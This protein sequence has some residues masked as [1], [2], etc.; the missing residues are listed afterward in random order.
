MIP[1]INQSS[2]KTAWKKGWKYFHAAHIA[3]TIPPKSEAYFAVGSAIHLFLLENEKFKERVIEIPKEVL[4]KGDKKNTTAWD[5]FAES[6]NDKVLLKPAEMQ[7]VLACVESIMQHPSAMEI[8]AAP[9]HVEQPI[10]A[11]IFGIKARGIPDICLQRGGVVVDVKSTSTVDEYEFRNQVR[12]LGYHIQAA[13]YLE[14]CSAF[15][16]KRYNQFVF[17]AVE[18]EPPYRCRCYYLDEAFLADGRMI[19]EGLAQEYARRYAAN[20]WLEDCD[21]SIIL[22]EKGKW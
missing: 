6:N 19:A 9:A 18:T 12:K 5:N 8:L 11:D 2:L 4:G 21:R 10:E 13:W 16:G 17:I 22:I 1:P 3:K 15:Y 14:L 7:S 20:D